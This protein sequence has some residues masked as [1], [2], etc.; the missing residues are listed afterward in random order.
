M[1]EITAL[2]SSSRTVASDIR[3]AATFAVVLCLTCS[4]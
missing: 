3:I 4:L 1:F 2:G